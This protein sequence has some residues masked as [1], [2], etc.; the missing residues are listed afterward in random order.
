MGAVG[1][2]VWPVIRDIY[3]SRNSFSEPVLVLISG[4]QRIKEALT[5]RLC[6]ALIGRIQG[7]WDWEWRKE[8]G[9][10]VYHNGIIYQLW[11][12]NAEEWLHRRTG[13]PPPGCFFLFACSVDEASQEEPASDVDS[14]QL[15]SSEH[16]SKR[17]RRKERQ[18]RRIQMLKKKKRERAKKLGYESLVEID[19]AFRRNEELMKIWGFPVLLVGMAHKETDIEDIEANNTFSSDH[20][21]IDWEWERKDLE[22]VV[23]VQTVAEL[24]QGEAASLQ[25]EEDAKEGE[26]AP[27]LRATDIETGGEPI[28]VGENRSLDY[29]SADKE[30]E[31][32]KEKENE[33]E[34]EKGKEKE[35]E[36]E[37]EEEEEGEGETHMEEGDSKMKGKVRGELCRWA[38]MR[39]ER[40]DK[41]LEVGWQPGTGKLDHPLQLVFTIL[42]VHEELKEKRYPALYHAG[43][44]RLAQRQHE[45]Y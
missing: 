42:R 13:Q 40:G 38:K 41:Y 7:V 12:L 32:E 15:S 43:A 17:K 39:M 23:S 45:R 14:P 11:F 5:D 4:E 2:R 33:D 9:I 28:D 19:A 16:K 36:E 27:L 44:R 30:K 31:K 3:L 6:N 22:G 18:K 10:R 35:Q 24:C 20:Q 21:G 8:D 34:E 26:E 37:N 1:G 25:N 29:P